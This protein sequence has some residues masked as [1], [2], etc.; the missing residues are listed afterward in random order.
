MMKQLLL[1]ALASL[2]LLQSCSQAN[3][4]SGSSYTERPKTAEELRAELLANEQAAPEHYLHTSG[5]YRRNLI[6]QLVLEGDIHNSASLA[7]FKDPVLR[8]TWLS[9]TGTEINTVQYQICEYVR[10][11]RTTHFKLKTLAPDDVES[12]SMGVFEATPID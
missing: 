12:V 1:A 5:T 2:P 3:S 10:A 6:D 7:S 8:V 9:K 11:H 4:Y